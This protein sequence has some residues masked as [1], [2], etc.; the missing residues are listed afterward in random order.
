MI[1]ARRWFP[2][3]ALLSAVP[4]SACGGGG[5]RSSDEGARSEHQ[6]FGEYVNA[7]DSLPHIRYFDGDQVSLNDRCPVRKVRMNR[8]MPP[9]YVNGRPVGFC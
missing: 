8:S 5:E 9:A 4:L 3:I 1:L 7:A 6:V 2:V